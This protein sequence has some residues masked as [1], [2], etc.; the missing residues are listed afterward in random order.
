VRFLL[1]ALLFAALLHARRDLT[2]LCLL[3]LGL[4]AVARGWSRFSLGAVRFAAALSQS[5]AFPG[6]SIGL[7]VSAQNTRLL[8]VWLQVGWE[9]QAA[10]SL[11][12]AESDPVRHCGLLGYQRVSFQWRFAAPAR[13]V[14]RLRRPDLRVAD[15]LGFFPREKSSGQ[16]YELLVYPRRVPLRTLSVPHRAFFGMPGTES[17]VQDPIYILGTRDYQHTQPARHIHWNASARHQRL[18]EKVFEPSHQAKVLLLLDVGTY[19]RA[20]AAED[21]ERTLEVVGSLALDL[22]RKGAAVGM[23]TDGIAVGGYALLPVARS[24]QQTATLLET[25]ARLRLES[26]GPLTDVLRS[27]IAFPRGLSCVH[28]AQGTEGVHPA[29]RSYL[30]QRRIPAV[31][32]VAAAPPSPARDGPFPR[33]NVYRLSDLTGPA[34]PPR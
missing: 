26:A 20:G 29:V 7:H 19:V 14:H 21:F 1:S 23:V 12:P 34:A 5:R 32:I 27:G 16:E 3:V 11:P 2:I 31:E 18:Q 17:P 4:M 30:R 24:P 8:P 6:E 22:D 25:L 28:F 13:G 9:L 15:P 10:G 33:R